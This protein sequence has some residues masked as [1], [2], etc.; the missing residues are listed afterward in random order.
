[1]YSPYL[2]IQ[3]IYFIQQGQDGPVK[4]GMS[5][6]PFQ[7]L[8]ALQAANP[9]QLYLIAIVTATFD[10]SETRLHKQ[11]AK[12]RI[13]GEWFAP[14]SALLD[15]IDRHFNGARLQADRPGVKLP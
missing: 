6:Q 5:R 11:F 15:W 2:P 1:M 8:E 7:R 12:D 10:C 4:I 14:S 3:Q 13:R 9:D